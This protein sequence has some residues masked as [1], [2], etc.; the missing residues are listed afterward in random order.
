MEPGKITIWERIERPAAAPRSVLSHQQIAAAAVELA[1]AEGLDSLSMRRL[2]ARLGVAAMAIYRYVS[3][4]QELLELMVDA[5]FAESQEGMG[6]A[7]CG[8]RDVLRAMARQ[9][10]ARMLRHPWLAQA[11]SQALTALT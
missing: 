3:S 6:E 10:R 7:P 11:H 5:T 9:N 4:K 2:A 1:D 8:W